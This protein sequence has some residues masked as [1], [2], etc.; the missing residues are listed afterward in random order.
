MLDRITKGEEI[1]ISLFQ[2]VAQRDQF[3]PTIDR[4]QPAVFE[5]AS[6]FLGLDAK[7]DNV[8]VAPNEWMERLDIG[9]GRSILFLAI[10]ID[11]AALAQRDSNN[12]RRRICAKEDG[13]FLEFHFF[14]NL[15][16][17]RAKF[18]E[19]LTVSPEPN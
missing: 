10:N 13:V 1:T 4:D 15:L 6:E 18:E 19:S 8:R 7:I 11:R 9:N 14:Y 3:F 16:S 5:I 2:A 12:A 17:F